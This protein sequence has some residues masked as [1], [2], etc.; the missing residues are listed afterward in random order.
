MIETRYLQYFLA[1][2]R[3]QNITRAAESLHISQP[4]LSKQMMDLE[5]Q[6]GCRLFNRSKKKIELTDDG[7]YFRARAR[8]M[9]DLMNKTEAA[10]KSSHKEICGDIFLGCGE[11]YA[12]DFITSVYK[13]IHMRHPKLRLNLYSGDAD[14]VMEQLDKGLMDIGLLL[15]PRMLDKYDYLSMNMQDTFV[16]IMPK[17]SALAKKEAIAIDELYDL[18]I[19]MSRQTWTGNHPI[20]W[21]GLDYKKL[22][23]VATFNLIYN[24][25]FLVEQGMGYALCLDKLVAESDRRNLT[26]RPI[27]PELTMELYI[28]TKKYQTFS[29]AVKLFLSELTEKIRQT[30]PLPMYRQ[31]S[32][33]SRTVPF[34]TASRE[35]PD[36]RT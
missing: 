36:K 15:A 17:D 34:L 27:V 16:L 12:L 26:S 4:T 32:I 8:E 35:R 6:L 30:K 28:V 20:D 18:P 25:T 29:P 21:K 31:S 5:A 22:N 10:L 7:M 23:I 1:I 9:L 3:E 14:S 13:E 11:T 24:A 19:I 33:A 2:A